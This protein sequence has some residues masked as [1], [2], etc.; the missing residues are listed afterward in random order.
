MKKKGEEKEEKE[1]EE[2]DQENKD[3]EHV[4]SATTEK[5]EACFQG[6][7]GETVSKGEA[8]EKGEDLEDDNDDDYDSDSSDEELGMPVKKQPVLTPR[9]SSRLASKRL[10]V[11]DDDTTSHKTLEPTTNAPPSTK[12][13]T[14]PLHQIP[15]PPPSPI[16]STPPPF[17]THTSP[18]L[19]FV[20]SSYVP[21]APLCSVLSKLHD[22]QSQFFAF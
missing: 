13:A 6:E 21:T 3:Q 9:K 18:G 11:M 4:P 19:G 22:F 1:K 5:A 15:S 17:N 2:Q 12:P 20:N 16:P 7:Q 10:V 14:S 8:Q